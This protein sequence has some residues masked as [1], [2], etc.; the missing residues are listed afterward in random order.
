MKLIVSAFSFE[1]P[2]RNENCKSID[3]LILELRELG[4]LTSWLFFQ[5]I[6][7]FCL[8]STIQEYNLKVV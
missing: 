4:E 2:Y 1:K 3:V 7:N 5:G 8:I 6:L